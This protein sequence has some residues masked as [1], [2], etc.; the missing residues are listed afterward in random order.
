M[1][2]TLLSLFISFLAIAILAGETVRI[3][4]ISDFAFCGEREVAWRIKRAA[5]SLGWKVFLDER[6]GFALQ[7]IN[8]LDWTISLV[9]TQVPL[10]K[11]LNYMAVFHPFGFLDHENK[12]HPIFE[13]FDGYL[14]TIQPQFFD[15]AFRSQTKK[16][17]HIPFYPTVQPIPYKKVA[18]ND[19]VTILPHWGNRRN[20]NRYK[21]L[22]RLLSESG[23]VKFYGPYSNDSIVQ[24][25]FMGNVP[26]D[27]ISMIEAL[28]KHGITLIL[29]SQQHRQEEIPSARIFEAAAASTVIISDENRFVKE[30]FGDSVY[31]I[32]VTLQPEEIFRQIANHMEEIFRNPEE[33]LT[34]AQ[35]AHQI[36]TDHF[37]MTDQLLAIQSMHNRILNSSKNEKAF[38]Q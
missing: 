25:G 30:H 15:T 23:F 1:K 3:G 29:H 20:G 24:K 35:Q 2:K 8:N 14:L 18:L 6:K 11:C 7:K 37:Q 26:F 10:P 17:F 4:I 12:L 22:Y 9:P 27:G 28:Q 32:D 19:L 34:K 33:A 13:A 16:F 31:Y 36:F 38:N 21:T 5:E